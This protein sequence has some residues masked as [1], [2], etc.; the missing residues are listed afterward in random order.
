MRTTRLLY[1]V[2]GLALAVNVAVMLDALT[3]AGI[4]PRAQAQERKA[5]AE[6]DAGADAS[7]TS[8][9]E[10]AQAPPSLSPE[11]VFDKLVEQVRARDRAL[12]ER[13]TALIEQE[14]QLQVVR[15]ELERQAEQLA[16]QRTAL[17]ARQ[18]EIEGGASP[19]F[20][21]LVKAY[22][23][24][25]PDNAAGALEELYGQR[26]DVV[27]D[28]VLS[29]KPRQAGAILDALAARNAKVAASLSKQIWERTAPK[30]GSA[31][32]SG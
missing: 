11:E 1:W 17:E 31:R 29:L 28:L 32:I 19:S 15:Q 14:R 20:D 7:G 13:E 2:L 24:M 12:D 27:I 18:R 4:V 30:K 3:S 10:D 9:P 25:D 8:A 26:Q 23:Q 21:S 5:A 6:A 22:G 16:R